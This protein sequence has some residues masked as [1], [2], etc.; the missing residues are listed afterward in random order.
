MTHIPVTIGQTVNV[1]VTNGE[2][3]DPYPN[4]VP[5]YFKVFIQRENVSDEVWGHLFIGIITY[6]WSPATWPF[7]PVILGVLVLASRRFKKRK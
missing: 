3:L 5:S 6:G 7:V 2:V 4:D 1:T